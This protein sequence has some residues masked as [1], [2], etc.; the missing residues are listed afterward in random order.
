MAVGSMLASSR[1]DFGVANSSDNH[2]TPRIPRIPR[3]S[4]IEFA[5]T[6]AIVTSPASM[7]RV[8]SKDNKSGGRSAMTTV[9]PAPVAAGSLLPAAAMIAGADAMGQ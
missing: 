4:E 9:S 2:R 3:M 5:V 7:R 1:N 6:R 8:R